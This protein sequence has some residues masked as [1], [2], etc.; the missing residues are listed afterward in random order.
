MIDK[1]KAKEA[2]IEVSASAWQENWR[3]Q[4]PCWWDL[5]MRYINRK[6]P[7][8][9]A[10]QGNLS[11]LVPFPF[12]GAKRKECSCGLYLKA[13]DILLDQNVFSVFRNQ[14]T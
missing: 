7:V 8:F 13:T 10:F 12:Q 4:C 6:P 5:Y 2:E 14:E 1:M 11:L 9:T 3:L